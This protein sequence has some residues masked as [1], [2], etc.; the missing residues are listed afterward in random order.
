MSQTNKHKN[1]NLARSL[2][3]NQTE[4]EA[5]LWAYLRAKRFHGLKFNRQVPIGDYIVDL[6]NFENRLIIEVDG[7]QH[8]DALTIDYDLHRSLWLEKQGYRVLRFWNCDIFENIDGVL[9]TIQKEL[10][11]GGSEIDGEVV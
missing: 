6:V 3:H 9:E 2:R 11:P 10:G 8:N 5:K 1:L 4:A 7:G